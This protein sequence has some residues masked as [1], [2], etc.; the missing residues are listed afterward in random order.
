MVSKEIERGVSISFWRDVVRNS[1]CSNV[2]VKKYLDQSSLQLLC[3]G[4]LWK[5]SRIDVF[6]LFA[7]FSD[8]FF[9]LERMLL[10]RMSTMLC[11]TRFLECHVGVCDVWLEFLLYA[12]KHFI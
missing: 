4:W 12:G 7:F 5:R 1:E 2:C 9:G 3:S 8:K 11:S 6:M 10:P